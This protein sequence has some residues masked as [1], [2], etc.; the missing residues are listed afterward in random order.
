MTIELPAR[1][2]VV[3]PDC[4]RALEVSSPVPVLTWS[5]LPCPH[6]DGFFATPSAPVAAFTYEPEVSRPPAPA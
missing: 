1:G 2:R 4:G 3:C 5:G 6:F